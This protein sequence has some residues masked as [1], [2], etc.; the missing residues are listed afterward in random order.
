M[1]KAHSTDTLGPFV[2]TFDAD[3]SHVSYDGMHIFAQQKLSIS[4]ISHSKM[5]EP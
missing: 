2:A 4:D 5:V 3:A 1:L